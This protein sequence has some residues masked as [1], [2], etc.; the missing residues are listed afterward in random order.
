MR[1]VAALVLL[2]A[3][4]SRTPCL[5]DA[6]ETGAAGAS[7]EGAFDEGAFDEGAF[8]E[9]EAFR[10]PEAAVSADRDTPE[11]ITREEMD[12]NEANDLWEAARNTP[13]VIL[14][15]GGRRNDS[16]FTVRGF[17]TDSVP[18]FV[19]GILLANPYR[20]EG[21]S[22][23]LLTGDMESVEI[24]KGFS[25]SLLGANTMGGA[26]LL[27]TAKPREP[28]EG[29]IKT[30]F[31]FDS[32]LRYANSTHVASLGTKQ[33]YFY[34][35]AVF[36]YRNVDHYRLPDS[37]EPT[38]KNPQQAGD[39]LWSDSDDSKLTLTAG[40][41]PFPELDIWLAYVY[42]NADKGY[43]P[44]DV[45]IADFSIWRWPTWKRH[46]ISANGAYNAGPFEAGLLLYFDKYDNRLD[47]YYNWKAYEAGIHAPHS[48][49]DEYSLG[50]RLTGSWNINGWNKLQGAVTYKK[51]D[52][53]ELRG[54]MA[55]EEDLSREMHINEDTWSLGAEYS[56][57]P[58]AP[59]TIKAGAGFNALVPN[60]YWN[61]E[62]E[63][64]QLL[65]AEYFIVKTRTMFLYTWQAG[66]FYTMGGDH[67]AR[68]TYARKNHFPTMAE[69]YSTRFGQNMPNPNL[70][71]EIANHL[72]LGYRG[73]IRSSGGA[74]L[75]L[76]AAAYYSVIDGKIVTVEWPNQ[77]PY[78][79]SVSVDTFRNLDSSSF[80]GLELAPE[81]SLDR[82]LTI[83]LAF[84]WNRYSI[85][86][87]Q[88]SVKALSYY[89]ELT[90]NG[91]MVIRP[92]EMLSIVPRAEYV[93]ERYSDSEGR[94]PLEGYFL[95]HIK[96]NA[97]INRHFSIG[98]GVENIFDTL[99]EIRQY[100]PMAGRSFN[101]SLTAQY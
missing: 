40:L 43:S 23:R 73:V 61:E 31:D 10:L 101:A 27:R 75:V 50:G 55:N 66:L 42:Q 37:F 44:P 98:L 100:S 12:R 11:L 76:N 16:N 97:D 60:E 62:N 5:A 49:Y 6:Q 70:G 96:I 59:L 21:D 19:D 89:P 24:Q 30:S 15:G 14:S 63:Y 92:V 68:L 65:G 86:H 83:G 64:N 72:E 67:E 35:K 78:N 33:E 94:Y 57:N 84:S 79:P 71:P 53:V 81:L 74:A 25:S 2:A 22:A 32:A 93:G 82:F 99:Y 20:G 17:G 69:R 4:V 95:A 8:D 46:S 77:P 1:R 58:W 45:R 36:Q 7:E 13:G 26:V 91:Y 56:I 3:L 54:S 28:L 52:H 47:E 9:G 18:V 48:D 87:S 51:E 88:N 34:G 80:W 90:A 85:Y 39:R 41:T 29:S 38:G